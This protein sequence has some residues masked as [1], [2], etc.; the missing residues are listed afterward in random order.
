M[1]R[2]ARSSAV[3]RPIPVEHPVMRT[4]RDGSVIAGKLLLLG[5]KAGEA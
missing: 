3:A 5:P 2:E 1:P 4:A